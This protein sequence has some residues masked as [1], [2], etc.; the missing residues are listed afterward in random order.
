MRRLPPLSQ[1]PTAMAVVL[2]LVAGVGRIFGQEPSGVLER[3]QAVEASLLPAVV[4]AGE[5]VP[6][7][8]IR[9]RMEHYR[10]PAVSVAVIN[11]GIVEWAEGYGVK[12]AGGSDSVSVSTLFQAASISKPV[13]AAAI[14]R[15]KDR[16]VLD[17]DTD[18]NKYL[19]SWQVKTNAYTAESPVTLRGLLAHN[20]GVTVHGFPGYVAG[21]IVPTAVDVLNGKGNTDPVEV[22]S[23]P[24]ER[25]RYSG[26]GYIIAQVL[27]EDLTG[28]PFHSV[29]E[30]EVVGPM[31]MS[32]STCEQPLPERL[33]AVAAVG[34]GSDGEPIEG[35]WRTH[36]EQA[37]AG[38]WT[39][40]TDLARFL[41]DLRSA[42]LGSTD[43]ALKP[44]TVRE[45]LSRQ[46]SGSGLGL[47]VAGTGDSV[48]VSHGG[49][50][51]GYRAFMVLYPVTG[52]GVAVMTNGEG[53]RELRMEVVRAVSRVYDWPDYRPEVKH[54]LRHMLVLAAEVLIAV[55][56]IVLAIRYARRRRVGK[57]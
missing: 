41:L 53:G 23:V 57:V 49:A 43:A 48:R 8:G 4:E 28:E 24:G 42:Y 19:Q 17:L 46:I 10:V 52:D 18:V 32:D 1:F 25:Q 36:P 47:V 5:P 27:L 26:G 39:T 30:S 56:V 38:L 44:A 12:R 54:R 51:M 6:T 16:G 31:G 35:R 22:V 7:W 3:Q 40:P 9:D 21:E 34:H 20:A 50:N 29:I 55:G 13:T 45:M 15:L 2:C 33:A 37:A 11:D 14:L